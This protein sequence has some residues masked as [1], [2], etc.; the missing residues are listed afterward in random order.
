M[1]RFLLSQLRFR[2]QRTVVLSIGILVSAV[3]FTLLTSAVETSAL[4]V[5]GDVESSWR[6]AYQILVRPPD[7]FTQVERDE[8][9]VRENYLGGIF[10]GITRQQYQDVLALRGVDVAAPIANIGYIAPITTL[11]V[12]LEDVITDD[13]VQLFRVRSSWNAQ[14]GLSRYP[15]VTRYVYYTGTGEF[16]LGDFGPQE[17]VPGQEEPVDVC[18]SFN[19]RAEAGPAPPLDTSEAATATLECY[20]AVSG[21]AEVQAAIDGEL[22]LLVAAVDPVQED[23]LIGLDDSLVSGRQLEGEEPASLQ[24]SSGGD[25]DV[26]TVPVLAASRTYVDQTLEVEIERLEP[27]EGV[28]V[29]EALA[30]DEVTTFLTGLTGE[31][32]ATRSVAPQQIHDRMLEKFTSEPDPN[33]NGYWGTGQVEYDAVA[34]GALAPVPVENPDDVY[35][36][37]SVGDLGTVNG[38]NGDTQFRTLVPHPFSGSMIIEDDVSPLPALRIIGQYDPERLPGFNPL[39]RVPL[40]TYY[41]PRATPADEASVEALD[42]RALLPTM[43]LG[44]YIAQP[45][46]V[47]TTLEASKALFDSGRFEGANEQAPISAIRVRVQGATG[48]DPVS[49][50]RIR[51]VASG[52]VEETGL[53]V[54]ITAGSSPQQRE[55]QLAEGKFGRPPLLLEEGWVEK[56]VAVRILSAVDRKSLALLTLTLVVCA[57]FLANGAFASVRTRRSELGTL[58]CLGW[59]RRSIFTVVLGELVLVG[60]LAGLTGT[61]IALALVRVLALEMPVTQ[62]A[63]VVPAAVGLTVLGGLMPAWRATRSAPLDSVRP[64]VVAG[65]GSRPVRRVAGMAVHNLARVPGRALLGALSLAVGVAALTFLLAVNFAFQG[66]VVGTLLGALVSVEVRPVDYLSVACAIALGGMSVADMSFLNLRERAPELVTLRTV[67]WRERQLAG[68]IAVESVIVGVMASLAG[69][70]IGA[71]LAAAV[72]GPSAGVARAALTSGLAG[73]AVTVVASLVP[74]LLTGRMTP[75]TVLAE[76]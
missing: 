11:R 71:G 62:V 68:L 17:V 36:N 52:I 19:G 18:G 44:G 30:S 50:E 70:A 69:A 76:E 42:G 49:Q 13:P 54:D 31:L 55:V 60:L 6:T 4:Q 65:R 33:L 37:A 75:P 24:P 73:V 14:R 25:V 72:G 57:L 66:V 12:S 38:A 9:L 3:A 47:L 20:S 2:W 5:R 63:L 39:S 64:P 51:Q 16:V 35:A 23:R 59:S 1:L 48:P 8:G 74:A 26:R 61:G 40:E 45:P 22:P 67:G 29:P 58:A 28:N 53:A 32:V 10:G 34:D 56:G 15:E 43:N 46:L 21:D 7:S 27:P 41:P